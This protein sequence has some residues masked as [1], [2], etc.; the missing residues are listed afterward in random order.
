MLAIFM[1]AG[2]VE[3]PMYFDILWQ[4]LWFKIVWWLMM[5]EQVAALLFAHGILTG[6]SPFTPR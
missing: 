4:K 5:F 1:V 3:C 6:P 2:A